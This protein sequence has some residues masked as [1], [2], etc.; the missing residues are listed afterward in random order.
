MSFITQLN[1]ILPFQVSVVGRK[2]DALFRI[3]DPLFS[4]TTRQDVIETD[5]GPIHVD[6][7]SEPE[8]FLSYAFFNIL[9]HYRR[10]DLGRYI[11]AHAESD[12]TFVDVGANLGI[13][14]LI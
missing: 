8:R 9:K 12:R 13:Y 1:A 5:A 3:L 11:E 14:S 6:G 10:S 7:T 4:L 2:R